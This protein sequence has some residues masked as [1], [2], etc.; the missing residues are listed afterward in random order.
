MSEKS[1]LLKRLMEISGAVGI[2]LAVWLALTL[3]FD[4]VVMPLI[5][6]HGHE[7]EIPDLFELELETAQYTAKEE[8]F[9]LLKAEDRFDSFYP[10]GVVIEQSP[11]PFTLS[12]I[13]RKIKVVVSGGEQLFPMP[14]VRGIPLKE[15]LFKLDE[16]GF[17]VSDDSV[18]LIFS[19]YYPEEV[20]VEQPYPPETMLKQGTILGLTVSM[21]PLP[22]KIIVPELYALS[23]K[24]AQEAITRTGLTMGKI[25][26]IPHAHADSGLV[27]E[28]SIPP[29]A[30]VEYLDPISLKISIG[31]E[32]YRQ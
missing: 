19:G 11:P 8:G 13:G 20:V 31:S 6:L 10:P 32:P 16:K 25:E 22:K 2:I 24:E 14:E 28:Q 3:M 1:R 26:M 23:L 15:A 4:K 7:R 9:K 17:Q 12:K 21:G 30:E 29:E 5:T 18:K 27:V